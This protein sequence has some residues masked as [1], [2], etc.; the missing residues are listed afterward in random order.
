MFVRNPV[1]SEAKVNALLTAWIRSVEAAGRA[2]IGSL[3]VSV[4]NFVWYHVTQYGIEF[5][6]SYGSASLMYT[7]FQYPTHFPLS[8]QHPYLMICS[9]CSEL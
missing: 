4:L 6:P 7:L 5:S 2:A 8:Y 3:K 1:L 9:M